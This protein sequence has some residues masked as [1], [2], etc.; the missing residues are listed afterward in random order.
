MRRWCVCEYCAVYSAPAERIMSVVVEIWA[1]H[2]TQAKRATRQPR[3]VTSF[4]N[5]S[6]S[7]PSSVSFSLP[8]FCAGR[9][10]F[11]PLYALALATLIDTDYLF[12]RFFAFH[13]STSRIR[14][15]THYFYTKP[16]LTKIQKCVLFQE[17]H[18]QPLYVCHTQC[19]C[20]FMLLA[21]RNRN[22]K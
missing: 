5:E 15:S 10:T 21:H 19:V 14:H 2:G 3:S 20:S 9:R 4:S 17:N 13:K 7:K 16:N 8:L 12:S 11:A 6:S 22:Q 18:H 1:K